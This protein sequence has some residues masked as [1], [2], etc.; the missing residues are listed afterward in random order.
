MAKNRKPKDTLY[1]TDG[2]ENQWRTPGVQDTMRRYQYKK[3]RYE[4]SSLYNAVR[5]QYANRNA[6]RTSPA[7]KAG[8]YDQGSDKGGIKPGD[9]SREIND[10]K[11][12][13][14]EGMLYGQA[15][16]EQ[17]ANHERHR[18]YERSMN[19][20]DSEKVAIKK[21][22]RAYTKA[23]KDLAPVEAF[24]KKTGVKKGPTAT[25]KKAGSTKKATNSKSGTKQTSAK[26]KKVTKKKATKK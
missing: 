9:Y 15:K 23:K 4:D 6:G 16:S 14:R 20:G 21:S 24:G 12:S 13:R 5:E 18:E 22:E 10:Y 8:A 7:A 25:K 2:T 1:R 19:A 11:I 17:A 3:R 26:K